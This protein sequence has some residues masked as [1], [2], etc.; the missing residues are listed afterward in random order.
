MD[1]HG[2]IH[3][4]FTT[5]SENMHKM[6]LAFAAAHDYLNEDINHQAPLTEKL[7]RELQHLNGLGLPSI[8]LQDMI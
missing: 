8:N 1:V 5:P 3:A 6:P 2:D 7:W 4:P